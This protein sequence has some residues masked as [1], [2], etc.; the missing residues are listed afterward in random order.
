MAIMDHSEAIVVFLALSF[1]LYALCCVSS[2]KS[3]SDVRI[4]KS[5]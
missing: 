5:G 1:V 3:C 2:S 4:L